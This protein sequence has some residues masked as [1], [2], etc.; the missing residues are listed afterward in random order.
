MF[1]R[2]MRTYERAKTQP[3][4]SLW[5]LGNEAGHGPV[6]DAM[7]AWLRA[8]D[9]TRLVHYEVRAVNHS[10]LRAVLISMH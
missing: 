5:S 10:T 9:D 6:H 2:C 7:A 1:D 3:C 8:K 4:V